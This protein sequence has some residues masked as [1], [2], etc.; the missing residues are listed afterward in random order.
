MMECTPESSRY[1]S[2]YS[3]LT[4]VNAPVSG[5]TSAVENLL[6][7]AF[8][9]IMVSML[10]LTPLLLEVTYAVD[11]FHMLLPVAGFTFSC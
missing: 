4:T 5:Q 9:L 2:V 8:L 6:L 10:L 1:Y 11:G 7:L 3:V